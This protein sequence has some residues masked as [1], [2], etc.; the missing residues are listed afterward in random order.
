M[1]T[2]F[3]YI[4]ILSCVSFGCAAQTIINPYV[5]R[6]LDTTGDGKQIEVWLGDSRA[7]AVGES[8]GPT[9]LAGTAYEFVS[10]AEVQLTTADV[11][12]AAVGSQMKKYA[13]D[14]N[15]VSGRKPVFVCQGYSGAT[16]RDEGSSNN[17]ASTGVNRAAAIAAVNSALAHYNLQKP[18]RINVIIGINDVKNGTSTNA[19]IDAAFVDF[20]NWIEAT[21]PGVIIKCTQIGRYAS[22]QIDDRTMAFSKALKREAIA[23]ANLYI[24]GNLN[25]YF[26]WNLYKTSPGTEPLHLLQAG[27]DK[28]GEQSARFE[29][30]YDLG[31][32][33]WTC[34][35]MAA[36]FNDVGTTA[37]AKWEDIMTN[38][39][40]GY[41]TRDKVGL[42][43]VTAPED[44]YVDFALM[45]LTINNGS[46][47]HTPGV[48]I[49]CNPT[50]SKYLNTTM[51]PSFNVINATQDDVCFGFKVVTNGHGTATGYA[52]G[53][54]DA[55]IG[56]LFFQA[57]NAVRVTVSSLT[58]TVYTT[59]T[60][61][62]D[63]T[64]YSGYRSA[65]S[66]AGCQGIRKAGTSVQS[67]NVTSTGLL[68]VTSFLG[69]RNNN[70]A[71]SNIMTISY[72]TD[73]FGSNNN[74]NEPQWITD[75]NALLPT[76]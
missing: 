63:N 20:L 26:S 42:Y 51:N 57:T 59:D 7:L 12:T 30:Y 2:L 38:K 46:A 22:S 41:L 61:F 74:F 68:S 23:R 33:K 35:V 65:A 4:F 69:A 17:W 24:V 50:G 62:Q 34:Q 44:I 53:A 29:K 48:G 58:A 28:L 18:Y 52:F 8:V 36:H 16:V 32:T 66:G 70:G 14:R 67:S 56:H 60:K 27:N 15:A 72:A 19:Q 71:V 40:T 54:Q 5:F 37:A 75:I 39:A 31:Y 21:W 76:L 45:N 6:S 9:T 73:H 1:K 47:V 64:W 10:G 13:L 49:A 3:K 11:S 55:V 25:S 43:A